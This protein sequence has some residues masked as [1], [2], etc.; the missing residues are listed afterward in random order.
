MPE[1]PEIR[2]VS[3]YLNKTWAG[4]S[5]VGMGWDD[6]F[7][8]NK[9]G[10]KGITMVKVPCKVVGVYPRG[11]L[12]IIECV[13]KDKNTIYMISQLGMEGRWINRREK[14][15]NFRLYFGRLDKDK[16]K[17]VITDKWYFDDQRHFGNF[18]VYD[19]L[20]EIKKKHGPCWLTT[21]LVHNKDLTVNSIR[22]YQELVSPDL[23]KQ[24]LC[25]KRIGNKQICDFLMDQKY[26]SG[27]GNYLRAEILYRARLN[28]RKP[29]KELK[30]TDIINLYN[31][32]L[33]Q[34]LLSYGSR[35]LTIKS[36]WDPEGNKGIC[37]LQ[38]YNQDVD[39]MGNP[40]EKFKDK[41]KR[42]VHWVPA[43]QNK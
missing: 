25:N 35:G 2:V 40:V 27:I 41:T 17:Y 38:V 29:I 15:S 20:D 10:I 9:T 33:T 24:K 42:T 39:P 23:F 36:Y 11:K 1:G 5:I 18:N 26:C 43:I 28:P 34:M 4:K 6:K 37:P 21:A 7:K 14:H 13:N 30:D 22:P 32:I 12:I 19:N 16:N 3:E 8:F 31:T